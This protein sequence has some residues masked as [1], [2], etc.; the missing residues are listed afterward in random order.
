[1]FTKGRVTDVFLLTESH[2]LLT[3]RLYL[4]LFNSARSFLVDGYIRIHM[5]MLLMKS[6]VP[7]YNLLQS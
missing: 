7:L 5:Y 6:K 3:P 1:M 2:T 4:R